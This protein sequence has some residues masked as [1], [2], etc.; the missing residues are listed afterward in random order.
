MASVSL[1]NDK[2]SVSVI[3]VTYNA[4]LF[5][6][7]YLES[8]RVILE[9]NDSFSFVL[10]DNYSQDQT[11]GRVHAFFAE[12]AHLAARILIVESGE[13]LG[14]GKGCNLGAERANAFNPDIYW[15]VNPDT[16]VRQDAAVGLLETLQIQTN[17]AFAGSTL[18]DEKGTL[19]SGAFRF[20]TLTRVFCSELTIGALEKLFPSMR[21]NI[22]IGEEAVKADWLTGAS[23]MVKREAFEA[24]S[25]FA[26]E[27]FLY[28]EEVDLFYRASKLG[29]EAFSTP[30]SVV[31]H[32]SGASTGINDKIAHNR[33]KRRPKYWFESR[34]HFYTS[35]FGSAYFTLVD[36][37]VISANGIRQ[38]KNLIKFSPEQREPFLISDIIQYSTFRFIKFW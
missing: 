29:Y 8:M 11:M 32:I 33:K 7:Q 20:P 24:L 27:Y 22:P 9:E 31:F 18:S 12:C 5:I 37:A 28:F 35:N 13:N 25:G 14:F 4:E 1:A 19:R 16:I 26:P 3:T 34:R 2:P 36:L 23:F 21:H 30:K 6:T 10:V 15:F 17:V 38:I